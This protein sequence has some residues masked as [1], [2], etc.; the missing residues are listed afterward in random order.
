MLQQAWVQ[1]S[2][3][4]SGVAATVMNYRHRHRLRIEGRPGICLRRAACR[5]VSTKLRKTQRGMWGQR[6]WRCEHAHSVSAQ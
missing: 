3:I 1:T 2:E 4:L 6:G 5:A